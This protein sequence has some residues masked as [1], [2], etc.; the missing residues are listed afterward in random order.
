[1]PRNG[2]PASVAR[3]TAARNPPI[4][5]NPRAQSA[6]APCPGSTIRSAAA[7]TRGSAVIETSAAKPN[8][9]AANANA[10]DA[11]A[12]FPLP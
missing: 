10:R 12:R 6:N 1:M 2:T 7:T 8:R 5:D 3:T 4:P 11:D 9:D